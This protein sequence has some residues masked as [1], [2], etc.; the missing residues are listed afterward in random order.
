MLA[1]TDSATTHP[2]FTDALARLQIARMIAPRTSVP[3]SYRRC[4]E[5]AKPAQAVPVTHCGTD[6][7]G[8]AAAS[9][10]WVRMHRAGGDA[11]DALH[12][13][14]LVALQWPGGGRGIHAV[15][16]SLRLVARVSPRTE[17]ALVDLAAAY[18]VRAELRQSPH[19]LMEAV[20]FARRAASLQPGDPAARFNLALAVDR[21]GLVERA[22]TAWRKYLAVDSVSPWSGEARRR[23]A[24]L[25]SS[26]GPPPP[27]T[28]AM[29]E[30]AWRRWA[31]AAPQEAREL[32][33]GRVLREW[34]DAVLHGDSVRVAERL[35]LAAALGEA[36][37][38]QGGD[39]S[40]ADAVR[41][42]RATSRR[43]AG[44]RDRAR[45]HRDYARARAALDSARFDDVARVLAGISR[46]GP[47]PQPL[48]CWVALATGTSLV[49]ANDRKG[50]AAAIHPCIGRGDSLRYPALAARARWIR[51]TAEL[52]EKRNAEAHGWYL[53]AER[54]Y[55]RAGEQQNRAALQYLIGEPLFRLG[56]NDEAYLWMHRA[57]VELRPYRRSP[58]LHDVL[59]MLAQTAREDGLTQAAAEIQAEGL[60]VGLATGQPHLVVEAYLARAR[61]LAAAGKLFEARADVDRARAMIPGLDSVV[62]RPFFMADLEE[63]EATTIRSPER[64]VEHLRSAVRRWRN[65]GNTLRRVSAL[66]KLADA[67]LAAGDTVA[68]AADLDSVLVAVENDAVPSPRDRALMLDAARSTFDRL[69]LIRAA[70]GTARDV[71]AVLERGR[72]SFI[73]RRPGSRPSGRHLRLAAPP[74]IVVVEYALVGDVLFAFVVRD[75]IVHLVRTDLVRTDRGRAGLVQHIDAGTAA[76]ELGVSE[77]ALLPGLEELFDQLVRPLRAHLGAPGTRLV[78]VADGEIAGVPFAAL[79]DS[80]RGTYLIEDYPLGFASTLADVRPP[81]AY[82][83]IQRVLVVADPAFDSAS[84]PELSRLPS[85]VREARAISR[86]YRTGDTLF[87]EMA[88]IESL[89]VRVVGADVV[90]LAVHA[91]SDNEQ[92]DRSYL[93]LAASRGESGRL[94]AAQVRQMDLRRTRLVV[95]S[96]CRTATSH[97]GRSGGFAGLAGAVLEAGAA[98]VVGTLWKVSDRLTEP[99]MVTF[100]RTY[101]AS[102]DGPAALRHAQLRMLRSADPELRS[103]SAWAGFRYAGN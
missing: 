90:H 84:N 6:D 64:G 38:A 20:E 17:P 23:L 89:T 79:R 26:H 91:V 65:Q 12:G 56:R 94:S 16:D 80:V 34:G 88:Q 59:W 36:L 62:V 48:G 42:I 43:R 47:L 68:A 45:A 8:A 53:A 5:H 71:L 19:D 28:A 99:L 102:G 73:A 83:P 72:A 27:P 37:E 95:L 39:G 67:E 97:G 85:S 24:E 77:A 55:A 54:L 22:D 82:G 70:H 40:L 10:L 52:R 29:R 32:G 78:F 58:W 51:G 63:T 57:T 61:V 50:A 14:A 98:S 11:V 2:G 101:H 33:W 81:R 100:H 35:R 96:A 74:G 21:M 4:I 60:Q 93:L 92:T 13:R 46:R 49:Y 69:M 66:G 75:T 3:V 41:V 87:A 30:V 86:E 76:L 103:P 7:A 25:H 15:I 9:R 18:I 31:A 44:V 1:G